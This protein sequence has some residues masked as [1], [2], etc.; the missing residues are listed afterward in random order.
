MDVL[1]YMLGKKASGGSDLD[2]TALGYEERPQAIDDGYTYALEI[3]NNWIPASNLSNK[4]QDDKKLIFMSLVDTST[5]TLMTA[6][7]QNCFGLQSIPLLD[8]GKVTLMNNMFN[9]CFALKDIPVLD[10]SKVTGFGGIFNSCRS[11]TDESLNNILQ[12]CINATSYKATKTLN[13]LGLRS[14]YYPVEKI[15][16]LPKYQDFIDA[17][18]TIGY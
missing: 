1:S 7:F 12:M 5:T 9:G 17:G 11:L 3:K 18:W 14:N 10:T 15:Q 8:T 6:M 2:W 13:Q 16:A 4:F